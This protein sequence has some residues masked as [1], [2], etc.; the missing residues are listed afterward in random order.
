MASIQ[1]AHFSFTKLLVH[2]LETSAKFYTSV[3]GLTEIA[4]VSD[5]INERAIDEILYSPTGTG[6]A[7]F[8]L[9][10]FVGAPKPRND[11][12]ILGFMTPDLEAFLQRVKAAGGSIVQEIRAMPTHGVRVA[13]VTDVEGH[14]IEVV[15]ML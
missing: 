14:L 11:E 15:Q 3:C 7:T 12:V 6:G 1:N 13:F 2:D 8:V 5:A 9:L 10:K 4:R